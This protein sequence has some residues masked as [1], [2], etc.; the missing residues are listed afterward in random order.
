M[1]N[2]TDFSIYKCADC[3]T[4]GVRLWR[5]YNT[6]L[7]HQILRCRSCAIQSQGKTDDDLAK[8]ET[9]S[10]GWLVPAVPTAEGDTFWGYSS[11]PSDRCNWWYALPVRPDEPMPSTAEEMAA[12]LRRF[13]FVHEVCVRE[14]RSVVCYNETEAFAQIHQDKGPWM[15]YVHLTG[16]N[17]L[18]TSASQ[19]GSVL[20]SA[21]D[22]ENIHTA[23]AKLRDRMEHAGLGGVDF[24]VGADGR[25]WIRA[26][27]ERVSMGAVPFTNYGDFQDRALD[28][29]VAFLRERWPRRTRVGRWALP[30]RTYRTLAL[31]LWPSARSGSSMWM[32]QW[33]R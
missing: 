2:Y 6:F 11:V 14:D 24:E 21:V 17:S 19:L 9:D 15:A 29:A 1:K 28:H 16:T 5:E 23:R 13:K 12:A 3:G 10:I 4:S 30:G 25:L 20:A 7:N 32:P 22:A 33:N 31:A 8:Y 26:S 18:V 27:G